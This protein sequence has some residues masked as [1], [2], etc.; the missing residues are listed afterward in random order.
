MNNINAWAKNLKHDKKA[1]NK[2][3]GVKNVEDILR[4]AREDGYSFT[5]KELLNFNLD[6]VSGGFDLGLDFDFDF[7]FGDKTNVQN[8][9]TNIKNSTTITN[10]DAKVIGNNNS[11]TYN[12]NTDVKQW[13]LTATIFLFYFWG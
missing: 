7:D 13:L 2:Y 1:A 6:T 12:S 5:E 11:I 4:I 10:Q 3:K 9:E 8:T